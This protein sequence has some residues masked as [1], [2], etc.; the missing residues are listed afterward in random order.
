MIIRNKRNGTNTIAYKA[1][2][3]IDKVIIPSGSVV[4]IPGITSINQIINK[5]D[6]KR[7][8][9]EEV[10][11][12]SEIKNE[13]NSTLKKAKEEAEEYSVEEKKNKNNKIK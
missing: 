9:F 12:V 5:Q 3:T 13:K 6:F 7:G 8:W 2:A 4:D 1:G 11:V 10:V